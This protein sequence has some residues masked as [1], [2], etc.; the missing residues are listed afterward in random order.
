MGTNVTKLDIPNST[1]LT[2]TSATDLCHHDFPDNAGAEFWLNSVF[3]G[4][5]SMIGIGFNTALL[6]V[7]FQKKLRTTYLIYLAALALMDIGI[8]ITYILLMVVS[9]AYEYLESYTLSLIWHSYIRFFY[10]LSRVVTL[11]STYLVL[12]CTLERYWEVINLKLHRQ[13]NMTQTKRYVIVACVII[14]AVA[15]RG[16]VVLEVT[17]DVRPECRGTM[18]YLTLNRTE[19]VHG[20]VYSKIYSFWAVHVAQVFFP[21]PALVFLN[22]AITVTWRRVLSM[23]RRGSME[24]KKFVKKSQ[25]AR[26]MMVAI[27]TSYL[28][29][30]ALHLILTFWEHIDMDFLRRHSDFYA[31]A[32]DAVTLLTMINASFRLP[33][34]YASNVTIRTAIQNLW[35]AKR[36]EYVYSFTR[37]KARQTIGKSNTRR[38]T[39]PDVHSEDARLLMA[40]GVHRDDEVKHVEDV[41]KFAEIHPL[42]QSSYQEHD[43]SRG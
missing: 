23:N 35:F 42:S 26:K 7:L 11:A 16:I 8:I 43:I 4:V 24:L 5:I 3:G 6:Q 18:A 27:V 15:F 20:Y 29:C 40:N 12:V 41:E 2:T 22:V 38:Q 34:Y 21:F 33:I 17:V 25:S 19:L 28:V 10:M 39:K 1:S 9:N 36:M 32:S 14:F 37:S 13:A 30:N 31:F